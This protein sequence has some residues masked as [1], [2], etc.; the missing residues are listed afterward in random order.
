MHI[1]GFSSRDPLKE[2]LLGF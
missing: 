1:I 2:M